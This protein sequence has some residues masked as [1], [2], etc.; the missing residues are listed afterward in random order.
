MRVYR[1]VYRGVYRNV[2]R[3][4]GTAAV[5][6]VLVILIDSARI[7]GV[8]TCVPG[9]CRTVEECMSNCILSSWTA[10]LRRPTF[11]LDLSTSFSV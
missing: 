11:F 10:F 6:A 4:V 7:E 1:G 5:D 9:D 3:P 2:Y 8:V